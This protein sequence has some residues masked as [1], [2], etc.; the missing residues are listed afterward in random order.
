MSDTPHLDD[1]HLHPVDP[2]SLWPSERSAH[3]PRIL[4]LYGSLR[5]RSYSRLSA[6]EGA[7]ILERLGAEVRIYDPRGLPQVDTAEADHPKVAELRELV[8]WC[9]GMGLGSSPERHGAMTGL[10]KIADR[11]DPPHDGRRAAHTR[12]NAGDHA[13]MRRQPKLQHGQPAAHSGPLDALAHNPQSIQRG[14]GPGMSLTPMG[15]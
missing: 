2:T 13:G 9:E 5:E 3:A 15:V 8:T 14:A 10:M 1:A 4:I 7:R 12:Q 11:L 6:E